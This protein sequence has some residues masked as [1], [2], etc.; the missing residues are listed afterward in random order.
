MKYPLDI[1]NFLEVIFHLSHLTLFLLFLCTDYLGRLSNLS[2]LF[3][4]TLHSE[5]YTFP[6][7]LCLLLLFFSQPFVRPPQTQFCLIFHFFFSGLVLITASCTMSQTFI[8]HSSGTLS[9][10]SNRI[11]EVIDISPSNLIQACAS[12]ILAFHTM[13]T[14]YKLNEHSDNIQP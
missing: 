5:G 13:F 7:F 10:R 11:P 3:F 6:L 9:I 8:H 1:S 4:R 2:L 12:S 14:A